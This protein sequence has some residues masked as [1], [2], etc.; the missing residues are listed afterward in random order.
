[1]E[2]QFINGPAHR[3]TVYV[4]YFLLSLQKQKARE[5]KGNKC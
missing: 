4:C 3:Q 2:E 5:G 1:M